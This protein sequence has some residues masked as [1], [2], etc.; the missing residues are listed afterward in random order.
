MQW[1]PEMPR[2][3][4][5][6]DMQSWIPRDSVTLTGFP[7]MKANSSLRGS[8]ESLREGPVACSGLGSPEE[9][10]AASLRKQWHPRSFQSCLNSVLQVGKKWKTGGTYRAKQ[11]KTV[12]SCIGYPQ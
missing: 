11:F 3:W 2:C 10:V 1:L 9:A 6:G 5:Q 12:A 7:G 4:I 8:L